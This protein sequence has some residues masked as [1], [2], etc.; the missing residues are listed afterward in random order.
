[1]NGQIIS[2]KFFRF[3]LVFVLIFGW[4][5]SGWPQIWPR[6]I[7]PDRFN[8]GASKIRIP[9]EIISTAFLLTAILAFVIMGIVNPPR[10]Y[11]GRCG[12]LFCGKIIL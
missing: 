8:Y 2:L 9:P 11:F 7:N 4:V 10:A 1:M 6:S 5:F 3:V 12:V